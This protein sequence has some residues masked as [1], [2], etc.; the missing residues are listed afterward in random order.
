MKGLYKYYNH[1]KMYLTQAM[2]QQKFHISEEELPQ[3]AMAAPPGLPLPPNLSLPLHP[4]PGL[5]P[6][7][8]PLSIHPWP[9]PS[10]PNESIELIDF[11][12]NS[13]AE[14]STVA[15]TPTEDSEK[16]HHPRDVILYRDI[17]M[18]FSDIL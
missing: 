11:E 14:V 7:G 3:M 2:Q 16:Y 10:S 8:L 5:S 17:I 13:N 18:K 6:P 1:L 4:P 9:R 15:S 12:H